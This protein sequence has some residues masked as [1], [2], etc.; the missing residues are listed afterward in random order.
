MRMVG[1]MVGRE[2]DHH[3]LRPRHRWAAKCV[4]AWV[5]EMGSHQF[6]IPDQSILLI[7]LWT[8]PWCRRV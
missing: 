7:G 1:S 4:G 5:E 6:L 3:H 8:V 2:T